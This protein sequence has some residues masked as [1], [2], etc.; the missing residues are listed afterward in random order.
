MET[1]ISANCFA[2]V[3]TR[4]LEFPACGRLKVPDLKRPRYRLFSVGNLCG[5]KLVEGRP[6]LYVT[7]SVIFIPPTEHAFIKWKEKKGTIMAGQSYK[8]RRFSS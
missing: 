7:T 6:K 8:M 4:M 1:L 5:E 2:S 3:K